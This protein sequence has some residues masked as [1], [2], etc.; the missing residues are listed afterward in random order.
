MVNKVAYEGLHAISLLAQKN[1]R[2][3]NIHVS[4]WLGIGMIE[5][6]CTTLAESKMDSWNLSN[7]LTPIQGS[8]I[9]GDDIHCKHFIHVITWRWWWWEMEPPVVALMCGYALSVV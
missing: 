7:V 6:S 8:S 4:V 2:K 1:I 5:N 3:R 9:S